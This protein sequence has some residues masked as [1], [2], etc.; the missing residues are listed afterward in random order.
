MKNTLVKWRNDEKALDTERRLMNEALERLQRAEWKLNV[1]RP[2]GRLIF[3]LDLTGSREPGL[4]HARIATAAMFDTIKAIGAVDVKLIYYRGR[5]ECRASI[6]H[7]DPALVSRSMLALSCESGETQIARLLRA[8]LAEEKKIS[9]VVFV[10]DHCED[11]RPELRSLAQTFGERSIPLFIFHE[12]A[13]D[14]ER[15][16]QAKPVFKRM[17]DASGGVYVEFRPDSGIVLREMLSNVA[18]LAAAGR[19]GVKQV[20]LPTTPEARQLQERLLLLPSGPPKQ[21]R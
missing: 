13:D 20:P 12:C 14:D 15:S 4:H 5:S 3:G 8:A 17:A 9:G 21:S 7:N 6:W 1:D 18:A 11:N 16:L 19:E 2:C 10:G